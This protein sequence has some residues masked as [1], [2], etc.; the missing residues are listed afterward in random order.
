LDHLIRT[1]DTAIRRVA[2]RALAR[3]GEMDRL[4]QHF[5][6]RDPIVRLTV[7]E[8][9]QLHG[10]EEHFDALYQQLDDADR[11]AREVKAQAF[12]VKPKS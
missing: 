5:R 9:I 7:A 8:A 10:R 3:A 2:A 4:L 6:D 1:G 11:W 12:A